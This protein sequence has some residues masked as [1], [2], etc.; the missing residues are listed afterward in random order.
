LDVRQPTSLRDYAP[1]FWVGDALTKPLDDRA[2][3]FE[4][5]PSI[6]AVQLGGDFIALFTSQPGPLCM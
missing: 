5:L 6:V 1:C 2:L 4:L 3:W